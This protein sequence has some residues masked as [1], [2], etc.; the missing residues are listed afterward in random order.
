MTTQ[1][2]EQIRA[3]IESAKKKSTMAEGR[4]QSIEEKLLKDFNIEGDIATEVE[5]KQEKDRKSIEKDKKEREKLY[6]EL[7]KCADWGNIND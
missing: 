5:A 6:N 4:K 2:F 3:S 7:E 1:K